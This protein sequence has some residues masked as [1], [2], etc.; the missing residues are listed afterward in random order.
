MIDC[1]SAVKLIE[2]LARAIKQKLH[3]ACPGVY[4]GLL[5]LISSGSMET[6]NQNS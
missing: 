5:S 2:K 4:I 3:A 6:S 1:A